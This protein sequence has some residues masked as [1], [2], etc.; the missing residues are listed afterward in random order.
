MKL[1]D[2]PVTITYLPLIENYQ[3]RF[4]Q[5]TNS[6]R[7][8]KKRKIIIFTKS[9]KDFF[10]NYKNTVP[11]NIELLFLKDTFLRKS[12][13]LQ[14]FIFKQLRKYKTTVLIDWFSNFYLIGLINKLTNSDHIYIFSPVI[15]NWGWVLKQLSRQIP[16]FDLRYFILRLIESPK[17]LLSIFCSSKVVVQSEALKEF[18]HKYYLINKE[19]ILVNYNYFEISEINYVYSISK[20]RLKVGFIGNFERHKGNL[21]L[22]K[23]AKLNS[24][25]FIIAGGV[26]GRKNIK[27]FNKIKRLSN[28]EVVGHINNSEIDNF[29]KKIDV[30]LLP[31]FHE[32]SPRV[33]SEFLRYKKPIITFKNPGIDYCNK[34]DHVFQLKYNESYLSFNQIL[35]QI[36]E[37]S[38]KISPLN[39]SINN[40]SYVIFN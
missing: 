23:L 22:L 14:F 39:L 34:L 38:L 19:K 21:E 20:D 2:K 35:K 5:L 25:E 30:L 32:G 10:N 33:I 3:D 15:S 6:A 11:K 13:F 1:K 17:E 37:N 12:L 4:F 31:S 26:K 36:K 16:F 18:Y 27:L 8:E 24:C 29:Y 40:K 28:V 9:S 7:K